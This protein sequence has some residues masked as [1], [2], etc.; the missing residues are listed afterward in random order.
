VDNG[1]GFDESVL[2]F[3]F[4]RFRRGDSLG[5]SGLGMAI[6][7]RIVE[8]HDATIAAANDNGRGAL[9]TITLPLSPDPR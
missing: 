2:P 1:P 4:D 7:K 8:A 3:V 9:V 5:S 6:A